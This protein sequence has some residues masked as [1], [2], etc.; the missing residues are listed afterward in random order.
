MLADGGDASRVGGD[1][2]DV[3]HIVLISP[4]AECCRDLI[5]HGADP[6]GQ[7]AYSK[8]TPMHAVAKYEFGSEGHERMQV[9]DLLL[10]AGAS[11]QA[12]DRTGLT[13]GQVAR[14]SRK[15]SDEVLEWFSR[16][17]AV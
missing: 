13:P 15:A 1:G 12:K 9:L 11:L 5:A 14:Q 2:K 8:E 7:G 16:H 17:E 3:L 4:D 6:C 10:D